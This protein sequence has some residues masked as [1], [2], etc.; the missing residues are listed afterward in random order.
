MKYLY[1]PTEI[2]HREIDGHCLLIYEAIKKGYYV[3]FGPRH[4]MIKYDNYPIG[5][6]LIKSLV[7]SEIRIF[8]EIKNKGHKIV[9]LDQEGLIMNKND[10]KAK[11]RY[12]KKTVEIS[13]RI[14][15]WGNQQK[16][17]MNK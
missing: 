8:S 1:I 12:N 15:M 16:R 3:F 13:D 14:L 7:Q 9:L 6:W 4:I 10:F 11:Q 2:T 5:S 17:L